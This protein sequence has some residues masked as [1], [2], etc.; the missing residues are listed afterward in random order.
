LPALTGDLAVLASQ[1]LA[2]RADRPDRVIVPQG[3][4]VVASADEN[5]AARYRPEAEV[6]LGSTT[7][8]AENADLSSD[9]SLPPPDRSIQGNPTWTCAGKRRSSGVLAQSTS[10]QPDILLGPA[11]DSVGTSSIAAITKGLGDDCAAVAVVER[12]SAAQQRDVVLLLVGAAVS[13]G[14]A[15]LV[16][17]WLALR[18]RKDVAARA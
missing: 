14:A 3:A 2:G 4:V 17:L 1:H 7:V 13:L 15:I 9:D 6:T 12:H 10:K 11:F 8:V 5:L 16:E 18:R